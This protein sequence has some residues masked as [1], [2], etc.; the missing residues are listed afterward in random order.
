MSFVREFVWRFGKW[1]TQKL[2]DF[3]DENNPD[4]LF[5]PIYPT[6]YMCRLQEFVIKKT[7][8]PYVCYLADDN[9]TF[10]S[11]GKNPLELLYRLFLRKNLLPI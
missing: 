6:I 8:K 3:I 5:I 2:C 11:C 7:N 1:K 4:V 10:K 9:Y